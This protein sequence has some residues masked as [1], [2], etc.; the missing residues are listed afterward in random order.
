MKKHKSRLA[1]VLIIAYRK[2][3]E[4]DREEKY[5]VDLEQ[6]RVCRVEAD[7]NVVM[8]I[9]DAYSD[10]FYFGEIIPASAK[11]L[12]LKVRT[13]EIRLSQRKDEESDVEDSNLQA[14]KVLGAVTMEDDGFS[15]NNTLEKLEAE[16]RIL[17]RQTFIG[18]GAKWSSK[19]R[20]RESRNFSNKSPERCL[21]LKTVHFGR[22]SGKSIRKFT[23]R[24]GLR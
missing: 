5:D 17:N 6:N 15:E 24:N 10:T 23:G 9:C 2:Q 16:K 19:H 11:Q 20:E 21:S 13:K 1:W 18:R 12:T 3:N 14:I 8:E 4:E 7:G 22:H